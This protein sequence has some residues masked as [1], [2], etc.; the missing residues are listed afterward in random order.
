MSLTRNASANLVPLLS[1]LVLAAAFIPAGYDKIMGEPV[2]FEGALSRRC[3]NRTAPRPDPAPNGHLRVD[4]TA[5]AG[6]RAAATAGAAQATPAQAGTEAG[7]ET[8]SAGCVATPVCEAAPGGGIE[9]RTKE[10]GVGPGF[11]PCETSPPP[12]GHARE[13]QPL[14]GAV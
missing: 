1:R 11:G 13:R 8:S 2:I 5:D 14:P 3:G 4:A 6:P 9:T 12:D 10:H 7:A